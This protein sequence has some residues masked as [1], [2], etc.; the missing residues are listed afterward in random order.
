MLHNNYYMRYICIIY[1]SILYNNYILEE[2]FLAA[3]AGIQLFSGSHMG[4]DVK[5]GSMQT[6]MKRSSLF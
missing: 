1:R 3:I 5:K 6:S 2:G 4:H